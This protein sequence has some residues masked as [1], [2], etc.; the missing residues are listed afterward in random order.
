MKKTTLDGWIDATIG[1]GTTLEEYQLRML[2]KTL[3]LVRRHS[4]Y[5]AEKFAAVS[6]EEIHTLADVHKLPFTTAKEVAEYGQGMLCVGGREIHRIV[7]IPTSGTS[8]AAKRLFFTQE[9]Q[10][11]TR[12]FFHHG[13]LN[14]TGP[15]GRVLVLLPCDTPGNT[16]ALLCEALG[17]VPAEA[18]PFGIVTAEN[19]DEAEA[20]LLESEADAIV[21][22]PT[23]LLWL[24]G[25]PL[26]GCIRR[27]GRLKSALL[28]TD[29][30]PAP[31]AKRIEQ[32][33]GCRVFEHYGLTE[34]GLGG[35][36]SCEAQGGYHLR[37]ADLLVEIVDA[38]TGQPLPDG[39]EGEVVFTT[40][41]R[42]AMPLIRYRT[43]DR[44]CFSLRPCACGSSLRTLCR[45]EGR[46][47]ETA[48]LPGG[49]SLSLAQLDEILFAVP[50]LV[51]YSPALRR[52]PGGDGLSIAYT[53]G[54]GAMDSAIRAGIQEAL[55]GS[56]LGPLI[57]AG[58]VLD[59]RP[60]YRRAED[61][62]ALHK[63]TWE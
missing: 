63:R 34:S 27:A 20:L 50:G 16:G 31:L 62:R 61:G 7:T 21:G 19:A 15:G 26:A 12:D 33:W 17:R 53:A 24:A 42:R 2:R 46:S 39:Q 8:G 23:Q 47:R 36:V 9:D 43:G 48:Q 11:L 37:E 13:M 5:G 56:F 58:C 55:E 51:D 35:G 3:A 49:I 60:G 52:G 44:A 25:G 30:V 18:L 38:E 45:V 1:P 22:I 54:R 40:L 4:R 41:T 14:L 10:E 6:P 29:H 59:I 28:A 32:A 57:A